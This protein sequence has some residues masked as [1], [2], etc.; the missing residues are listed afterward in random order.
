M[1][2]RVLEICYDIGAIPGV[3][4]DAPVER[5]REEVAARID[6]V[7]FEDGLGQGIGSELSGGRL[8]LRC[9]VMDFDA[10]EARLRWALDD[11]VWGAPQE[12]LRTW[13]A[14]AVA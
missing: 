4:G 6:A 3:G 1:D 2:H 12:I 9:V 13:D 14:R 8:R 11:T 5:L 10:A 7:L